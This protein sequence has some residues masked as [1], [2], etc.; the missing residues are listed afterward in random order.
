VLR[1][2]IGG[3]RECELHREKTSML[4]N[5]TSPKRNTRLNVTA[6][7]CLSQSECRL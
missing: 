4:G 5:T 7:N 2:G 3:A 1:R 6:K